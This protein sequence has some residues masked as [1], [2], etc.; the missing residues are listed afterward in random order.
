MS[1]RH[2]ALLFMLNM[3]GTNRYPHIVTQPRLSALDSHKDSQVL[4]HAAFSNNSPAADRG[5]FEMI[6]EYSTDVVYAMLHRI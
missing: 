5:T 4:F 3:R 2:T 1:F 6:K